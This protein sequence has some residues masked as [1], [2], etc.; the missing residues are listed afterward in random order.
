MLPEDAIQLR[1]SSNAN[2]VFYVRDVAG[3]DAWQLVSIRPRE[4][5]VM[6]VQSVWVAGATSVE[7]MQLRPITEAPFETLKGDGDQFDGY[8][9]RQLRQRQRYEICWTSSKKAWSRICLSL[10]GSPEG[11]S[12]RSKRLLTA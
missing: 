4:E 7:G 10:T 1:N 11:I 2:L 6:R 8:A 9:I 12:F 5:A 3:S